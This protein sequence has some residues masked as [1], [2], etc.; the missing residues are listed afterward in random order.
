MINRKEY[1]NSEFRKNKH[2][3]WRQSKIGKKYMKKY[4]ASD[5]A[6]EQRKEYM[7][8]E[9]GKDLRKKYDAYEKRKLARK[10]YR[11]TEKGKEVF[12]MLVRRREAK[13][14]NCIHSFSTEEWQNK[15][16]AGNGICPECNKNVGINKITMDH[17]YPLSKANEDF[18]NTGIKRIYTIKDIEPL[19][20][21]CNSSKG[22][23]IIEVCA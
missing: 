16:K 17:I 7:K 15:I 22:N 4:N 3:E 20:L 6:I 9:R 12:R 19:C 2:K 8:S 18:L 14:N 10:A 21:S 11:Q 13:K 23:K 5:K 1:D